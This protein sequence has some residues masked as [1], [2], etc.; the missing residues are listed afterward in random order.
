MYLE[1]RTRICLAGLLGALA[2]GA[3]ASSCMDRSSEDAGSTSPASEEPDGNEK[4]RFARLG[5]IHDRTQH[6]TLP[7]G[8]G[9]NQ[10]FPARPPAPPPI[11]GFA[12]SLSSLDEFV[13]WV[14]RTGERQTAEVKA[15]I[16]AARGDQAVA[17]GLIERMHAASVSDVGDVSRFAVL[18]SIVG[19]LH[20]SSAIPALVE[21]IGGGPCDSGPTTDV[22]SGG[23]RE[24]HSPTLAA[25][26]GRASEMLAALTPASDAAT[27]AIIAGHDCSIVRGAAIDAYLF[28]HA[29]SASA[30]STLAAIVR[31][32]DAKLIGLP[33]KTRDIDLAEFD[34]RVVQFYA[35]NPSEVPPMPTR[36]PIPPPPSVSR[37]PAATSSPS[38]PRCAGPKHHAEDVSHANGEATSHETSASLVPTACISQDD[39][40]HDLLGDH[41]PE[42]IRDTEGGRK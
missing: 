12:L 32:T 39:D 42:Q 24:S 36:E 33:R 22:G 15:R 17:T 41:A 11:A 8:T 35:D 23:L 18:L 21:F 37:C 25:L 40:D 4:K 38:A 28:N 2:S 27:L 13:T 19:E 9:C 31:S 34:R 6:V 3:L 26:R 30:A 10:T 16:A 7:D 20:N 1:Q 14:G 29:D 5:N